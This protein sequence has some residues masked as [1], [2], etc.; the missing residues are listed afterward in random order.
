MDIRQL[1]YFIAVAESGSFSAASAKLRISQPSIGQQVR[2]LEEELGT[3]LLQRHSR[4]IVLTGIG[5]NFFGLAQDIVKQVDTAVR[6]IKDQSAEPFGE[7]RIGM[8]VSASAPLASPLIRT[9]M[10]KHPRI[11][12]SISEALSHYLVELLEQD[13]IDLALAFIGEFPPGLRGEHLVQE[14]FHFCVTRNHPLAGQSEVRMADVLKHPLLLPPQ[15]HMLRTQIDE[16]AEHLGMAVNVQIVVQSIGLLVD[17][18]EHEI[19]V[20]VLPYAAAARQVHEGRLLAIP[21]VEPTM[22]RTMTLLH[23]ARRP[24]TNA[25][26]SIRD[27]IRHLV[28]IKLEEGKMKWR[29]PTRNDTA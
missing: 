7:V 24:M 14:D 8:T 28:R 21:I 12:L 26:L 15:S 1:R 17:F 5:E 11:S 23:S 29:L 3:T 13:H 27:I 16:A 2:N 19:G 10:A 18:V 4:G 25:E 6:T 20:T 22:T 9:A